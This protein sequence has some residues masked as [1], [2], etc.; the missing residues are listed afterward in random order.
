M[1]TYYTSKEPPCIS[2]DETKL[3]LKL[4]TVLKEMDV[5]L[6]RLTRNLSARVSGV[7]V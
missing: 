2:E 5:L 1:Y 3:K 7:I 6:T 4:E